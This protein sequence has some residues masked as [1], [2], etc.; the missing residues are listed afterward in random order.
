VSAVQMVFQWQQTVKHNLLSNL[1]GHQAKALALLSWTM[2]VAGSCCAGAIAPFAPGASKPSS[3]RRRM[4]RLL[5]NPR[6]NAAEA[7]L[8][9]TRS[10]L[11]DWGGRSVLMI[12]DETPKQNHLRCMKLSVAYRKR[13]VTLLSI[14]YAPDRPPMKMPKLVRWMLRQVAACLPEQMTVTLLADRGLCWPTIIRQCKK[15]K[16]HFLLRLQSDTRIKLPDGTVKAVG[17]LA[18]RKGTRWFGADVQVFKKARWLKANVAAVWEPMCKEPWLLVTDLQGTY[19]CCRG[20]CKRTWCEELHRDEKSHGLNWQKSQVHTPEHAQCLVLL[21]ALSTLLAIA[22]GVKA[23]KRGL[24]RRL[25]EPRLRRL[26]S[27]FR[28]GWHY[29]EYAVI[30]EQ[31]L[32][33]TAFSLPPP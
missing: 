20:Y 19:R 28:L 14:C 27:V 31:P 30:H 15:L 13:C 29:L 12:L 25:F 9:L 4:E 21:M 23:I 11:R 26:M 1:H 32:N 24:R 2:A 5:A 17:E 3:T 8:D 7:M 10:V 22:T 16:W 33:L 6:L 18:N